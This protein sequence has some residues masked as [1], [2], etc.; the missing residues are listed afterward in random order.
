MIH[1]SLNPW[2][3]LCLLAIAIA[4][5]TLLFLVIPEVTG[6]LTPLYSQDIYPDGYDQLA[7][8]LV[9]GNGYRFFPE[10]ASTLMREP[11]YPL[12][13]AVI[14]RTV[15]E[16]LEAVKLMNMLFAF[17]TALLMM[18][19]IRRISTSHVLILGA[20]LLFLLHPA[21]V[22]AESRGGLEMLF[23]FLLALFCLTLFRAIASHRSWDY[24]LSGAVPGL[25]VVVRSTLILFPLVLL[26]YVLLLDRQ[27]KSIL[28]I[29]RNI[30]LMILAMLM[31]LSPW[32]IRNFVV[33]GKFVPTASVVG[34]SAHAG[35]YICAHLSMNNSWVD[36]D[37]DAARER[38]KIAQELGYPF[39][40][41]Y[42][43][44]FYSSGDEIRFSNDLSRRVI[45]EYRRSPGLLIKCMSSNLFNL[46]FAGKTWKSTGL[47]L[48]VQLPYLLLAAI[49]TVVSVRS[50]RFKT[51][52][53]MVL[54]ILYIMAVHMP[55]LA[56]ARY[57]VP[58][59]PFLSILA[60]IGLVEARTRFARR[61]P[62]VAARSR[63]DVVS[64]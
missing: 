42:Y 10:T 35:Q 16:R 49:G 50:G 15:G 30:G 55:I 21:I 22:I 28:A 51:I 57:S 39:K 44:V 45:G 3:S 7:A 47:N 31:V 52:A 5:A 54:I 25:T 36:L 20:P 60:C 58:L 13:L 26:A 43:Q 8:N 24:V 41:G 34:V 11:G 48:V 46:W 40:R 63:E 59:I 29:C 32:I 33:T 37:E 1:R 53:P 6:R 2:V 56:Q 23:G 18:R 17:A 61:E 14:F 19:I 27:Q 4:N 38:E 62:G 64:R 12:L 9:A